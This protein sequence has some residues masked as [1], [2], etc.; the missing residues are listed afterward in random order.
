M[1]KYGK[2]GL[3]RGLHQNAWLI[4]HCE[5]HVSIKLKAIFSGLNKSKTYPYVFKD[6]PEICRDLEWF[7]QRFP[8]EISDEDYGYL[9]QQRDNHLKRIEGL[10]R[11]LRPDYTPQAFKING[12]LR[13]YQSQAV[14]VYIANQRLLCADD[15]GLGKTLV[16]VGSMTDPRLL[17]ACVVVQTHLPK[18]WQEQI[19]KFLGA[20]VHVIKGT[21]PYNL[22]AADIYIMKYSC[23]SGWVDMYKTLGWKSVIFDE[24][25]ELRLA[26]SNKYTAAKELTA[27]VDWVLGLTATPVY[28]YG[29]EIFNVVNLIK[30][31]SLGPREAFLREWAQPWDTRKIK[32]PAA[33]GTHLRENFLMLRRTREEVG[34][35]LPAVNKIVHTV[36]YD[37]SAV[38][39]IED[40]AR[41]LAIKTTTGSFVER[42]QA[43]RELDHMLRQAT[44]VSKAKHV[45]A[46]VKMLLENGE[47]VVLAGWHREVYSIWLKELEEYKPVM[48]TGSESPAQKEEA[49]RK[50]VNGETNLFIIS[51]RSGIGLDGLQHH[52]KVVVIG[53]LDWSPKVHEQ[54]IGRV[55]RDGQKDRVTA[56]YLVSDYG[57]DPTTVDVLGIKASQA[58]GINDP[59]RPVQ[60]QY[61]DESRIKVLAENFLNKY[62]KPKEIQEVKE[63]AAEQ[64]E[65]V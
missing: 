41:V 11:L 50:F 40:L 49:K 63:D 55:D 62:G 54:L 5:P 14:E 43:G 46:Y 3:V 1:R 22:P 39:K 45:A 65:M 34:M 26:G 4:E 9:C 57:S 52:C 15:V 35:Q 24:M 27:N 2:L 37:E 28:N 42:G 38:K 31:G 48:Y 13:K 29:D 18:Q 56:I 16:G 53:E 59:L 21:K 30:D 32:D 25:Q 58:D 33:L 20:K 61:T 47:P 17:P 7:I 23:L 6:Q 60:Q 51:L 44:G 36:E 10:E 19:A 12:Q 8:L 64:P